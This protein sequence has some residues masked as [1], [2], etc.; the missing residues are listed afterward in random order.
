MAAVLVAILFIMSY[1]DSND[2]FITGL[3]REVW[4]RGQ[5]RTPV[6]FNFYDCQQEY[7]T[8]ILY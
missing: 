2:D 8:R 3:K 6:T 5:G 4:E 7:L 1:R